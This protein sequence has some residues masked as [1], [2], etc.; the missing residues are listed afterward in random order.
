MA[1]SKE[2]SLSERTTASDWGFNHKSLESQEIRV[3]QDGLDWPFPALRLL[4]CCGF[5]GRYP[6][7]NT[8]HVL[9]RCYSNELGDLKTEEAHKTYQEVKAANSTGYQLLL[10]ALSADPDY[11]QQIM[12]PMNDENYQGGPVETIPD[13]EVERFYRSWKND[14]EESE[15][16]LSDRTLWSWLS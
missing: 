11:L 16:L 13:C 7:Y 8:A 4:V 14:D 1:T 10:R 2:A 6:P 3:L 9:R 12:E 15:R 5:E